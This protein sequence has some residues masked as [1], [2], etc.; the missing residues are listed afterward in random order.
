[1]PRREIGIRET[2]RKAEKLT[3]LAPATLSHAIDLFDAGQTTIQGRLGSPPVRIARRHPQQFL[4][5]T[6][7]RQNG[8]P[9]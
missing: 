5:Q 3:S 2:K 7:G 1:M 8:Q 9:I 4:K 6:E